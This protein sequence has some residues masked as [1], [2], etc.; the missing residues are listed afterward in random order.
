LA[1]YFSLGLQAGYGTVSL[2]AIE[3]DLGSSQVKWVRAG[4]HFTFFL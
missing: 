3:A 2:S 4:A 1:E